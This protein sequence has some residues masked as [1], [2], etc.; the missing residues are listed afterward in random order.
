MAEVEEE[1]GRYL[2]ML[3]D[4]ED[5]HDKS[6]CL[7]DWMRSHMLSRRFLCLRARALHHC[8]AS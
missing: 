4:E 7:R 1:I 8:P 5:L 6:Q 3:E 2:S